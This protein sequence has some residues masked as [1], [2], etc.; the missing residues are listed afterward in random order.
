[1]ANLNKPQ[2]MIDVS[3][4]QGDIDWK[5]IKEKGIRWAMIRATDGTEIVDTHLHKNALGCIDNDIHFGFYYVTETGWKV[6]EFVGGYSEENKEKR[7]EYIK[8]QAKDEVK[9]LWEQIKRYEF[10]ID[11]PIAIDIETKYILSLPKEE[12]Y[13]AILTMIEELSSMNLMVCTY[14]SRNVYDSE[15]FNYVHDVTKGCLAGMVDC[16]VAEYR[17]DENGKE[18][19]DNG[20]PTTDGT[21]YKFPV[22]AWQYT[23]KDTSYLGKNLDISLLY[24][25]FIQMKYQGGFNGAWLK[26]LGVEEAPKGWVY[27]D[28]RN[29]YSTQLW[30]NRP[31]WL[32][33]DDDGSL[34]RGWLA[35]NGKWYFL[36]NTMC[37]MLTG[38][39]TMGNKSYFFDYE[40]GH[41]FVDMWVEYT[42]PNGVVSYKYFLNN[43]EEC[44]TTKTYMIDGKLWAFSPFG[45]TDNPSALEMFPRDERFPENIKSNGT[46]VNNPPKQKE[47]EF[48]DVD[49]N[50]DGNYEVED[51]KPT[52]EPKPIKYMVHF[53]NIGDVP[54]NILMPSIES[55]ENKKVVFEVLSIDEYEYAI[56]ED[57][58]TIEKDG[59]KYSFEMPNHNVT[60]TIVW[61]KKEEQE[62]K[63]KLSFINKGE[64]PENVSDTSVE[65][66]PYTSFSFV[67]P[68]KTG[69]K[70]DVYS[71]DVVLKEDEENNIF[72][73]ETMPSKDIVVY[74]IW[75]QEYPSTDDEDK[76]YG[77][78]GRIL[79]AIISMFKKLI[80]LVSR[81]F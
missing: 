21:T 48:V 71:K 19:D 13:V 64:V 40:D 52:E 60:I 37:P 69:Y 16:W 41:M 70:V 23:S 6:D 4:F 51:D 61:K 27:V 38:H 76:Q 3:Q 25:D 59:N 12:F 58:I 57:I 78:I 62:S 42:A 9:K 31:M 44:D 2:K 56:K 29:F 50:I 65:F 73:I 67:K 17:T 77:M 10:K 36:S 26:G 20:N 39:V 11:L 55:E 49:F 24:K 80:E 46:Y 68:L 35:G 15:R 33:K 75:K 66:K 22:A 7:L 18:C 5:S 14:A 63:Y 54:S 34:R 30:G 74:Y 1:M 79:V 32:Y 72:N 8:E 47:C 45:R 53:D 43:G 81:F 28:K